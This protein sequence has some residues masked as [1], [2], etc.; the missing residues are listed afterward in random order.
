MMADEGKA[1]TKYCLIEISSICNNILDSMII[2]LNKVPNKVDSMIK[3][4]DIIWPKTILYFI[5]ITLVINLGCVPLQIFQFTNHVN[6][7]IQMLFT[8]NFWGVFSVLNTKYVVG[9][10]WC[11][12]QTTCISPLRFRVWSPGRLI[13]M[14]TR[15][16]SSK[17]MFNALPNVMGFLRVLQ[18]PPTGN[19]DRGIR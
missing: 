18:F 1:H 11:C 9:L 4:S 6:S 3:C 13:L 5:V 7:R 8:N 16:Q 2:V 19:V 14:W 12:G 17:S 15:T 10:W